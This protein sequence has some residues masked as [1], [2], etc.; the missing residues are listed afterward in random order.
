MMT[1][2]HHKNKNWE[3]KLPMVSHNNLWWRKPRESSSF[4][5][6]LKL[7]LL[8]RGVPTEKN[9]FWTK[10]WWRFPRFSSSLDVMTNHWQFLF[11]VFVLLT[12]DRHHSV[13]SS[14]D[15]FP[16]EL[17]FPYQVDEACSNTFPSKG[18]RPVTETHSIQRCE[19]GTRESLRD[20]VCLWP[21]SNDSSFLGWLHRISPILTCDPAIV[22]S[23]EL[24]RIA[25][26]VIWG[27]GYVS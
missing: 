18:A 17:R 3:S 26:Q 23:S 19:A 20:S 15:S 1:I 22:R 14:F 21:S 7:C 2:R 9:F 27:E 12:T 25:D 16:C 10:E 24:S 6:R 5:F 4:F 8:F 11:S 13:F